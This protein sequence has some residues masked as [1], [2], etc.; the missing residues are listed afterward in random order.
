M[1]TG[2]KL[3]RFAALAS[4]LTLLTCYVVYSHQSAHMPAA[5]AGEVSALQHFITQTPPVDPIATLAAS[6][7]HAHQMQPALTEKPVEAA[8]TTGPVESIWHPTLSPRILSA[9]G[10]GSGSSGRMIPPEKLAEKPFQASVLVRRTIMPGSKSGRVFTS[11]P[12]TLWDGLLHDFDLF[13]SELV[14]Q[15]DEP[16]LPALAGKITVQPDSLPTSPPDLLAQPQNIQRILADDGHSLDP[17]RKIFAPEK[18]AE[19]IR[20]EKAAAYIGS[21]GSKPLEDPVDPL[22]WPLV[23]L[24]MPRVVH[25]PPQHSLFRNTP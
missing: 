7:S 3:V 14:I 21:R 5:Q 4:S 19:A 6:D 9:R 8:Q 12:A 16:A 24:L 2:S 11:S 13:R 20:Y 25:E 22:Y 10:N 17:S 1:N 15:N 23:R 18:I